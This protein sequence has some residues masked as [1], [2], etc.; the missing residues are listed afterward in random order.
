VA[1]GNPPDRIKAQK[2]DASI[3]PSNGY[4]LMGVLIVERDHLVAEVLRAVCRCPMIIRKQTKPSQK[5]A[6]LPIPRRS[7][8]RG[9]VD[10]R[11]KADG[12]PFPCAAVRRR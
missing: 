3:R 6:P 2:V 4:R 10:Y 8:S 11:R 12:T 5:T 1:G 7:G 9:R